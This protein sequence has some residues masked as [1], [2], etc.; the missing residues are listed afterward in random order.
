MQCGDYF[1]KQIIYQNKKI[2]TFCEL[3][4]IGNKSS[5]RR[6]ISK[7]AL[8]VLTTCVFPED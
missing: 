6:I 3:M 7:E 2:V 4:D 1:S 8:N 5:L